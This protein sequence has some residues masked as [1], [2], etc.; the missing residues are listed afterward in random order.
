MERG[1]AAEGDR[2]QGKE[3]IS[4]GRQELL[5]LRERGVTPHQTCMALHG[6]S[7]AVL[8]VGALEKADARSRREMKE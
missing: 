3:Q 2:N 6:S 1:E 7:G 8:E 4:S 5:G